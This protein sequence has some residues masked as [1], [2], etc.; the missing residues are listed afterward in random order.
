MYRLLCSYACGA[1]VQAFIL[2]L[3]DKKGLSSGKRQEA[4]HAKPRNEA[5]Q[6]FP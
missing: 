5:K 3:S 4:D 6:F 1:N 2:A